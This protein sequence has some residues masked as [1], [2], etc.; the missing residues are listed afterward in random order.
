MF[1]VLEITL[2]SEFL[3]NL[4]KD[5]IPKIPDAWWLIDP[6]YTRYHV[7]SVNKKGD[8]DRG[9]LYHVANKLGIR[10][11]LRVEDE[12]EHFVGE[13][14][15]AFDSSW[16]ILEVNENNAI[17]LCDNI[18]SYHRF[19]ADKNDWSSSEIKQLFEI[20]FKHKIGDKTNEIY[21]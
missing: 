3:Y 16:T 19:S 13:K 11:V 15:K 1:K 10:P 6:G 7:C 2:L 9:Y 14:I 20:F 12:K 21:Y 5:I 18:I 8:I 4:H 17:M